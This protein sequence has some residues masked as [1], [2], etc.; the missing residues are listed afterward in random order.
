MFS[1][2]SFSQ[3][4]QITITN[5]VL[6]DNFN[7]EFDVVIKSFSDTLELTSYQVSLGYHFI[8]QGELIFSYING[9]SEL[10][11]MPSVAIGILQ[12]D[13]GS[14]LTF[15]SLPDS[16]TAGKIDTIGENGKRV[17][18]FLLNSTSSL[19][20]EDLLMHWNFLGKAATIFTGTGFT[21]ITNPN[22]HF[23][24]AIPNTPGK[25]SHQDTTSFKETLINEFELFQNYPN[26]FNPITN[27][28]FRI[29]DFGFVSLKVFD[30]LGREVETL[31]NEEKS[32]GSYEVIFNASS[33][34]SGIY[35]YELRTEKFYS[36]KKMILLK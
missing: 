12:N 19:V 2:N 35:Y 30:V 16:E 7:Y 29:A 18:R 34:A 21:D 28:E 24:A 8:N 11:N 27:F 22:S 4:Y 25:S 6:L 17:G 36:V 14:V 15:A 31:V 5:G 33:L 23:P 10:K 32:P 3:S 26:P 20:E 13:S 1:T 9:T